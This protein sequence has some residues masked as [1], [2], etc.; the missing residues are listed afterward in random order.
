MKSTKHKAQNRR[1]I[2]QHITYHKSHRQA[3]ITQHTADN[4]SYL[5][6]HYSNSHP[7]PLTRFVS[8][9]C[10]LNNGK[11]MSAKL[12]PEKNMK[13]KV[14]PEPKMELESIKSEARIP[15]NLKTYAPQRSFLRVDFKH[16]LGG[17]KLKK[18][19]RDQL[20]EC[21]ESAG[22]VQWTN[23]TD[24]P[25]PAQRWLKS[26]QNKGTR[27]RWSSSPWARGPAN[28]SVHILC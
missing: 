7:H 5:R 25:L 20:R 17:Q 18:R 24:L 13:N 26:P 16:F 28:Y 19:S 1:R 21:R 10:L 27:F 6:L 2:T 11:Q 14:H 23:F 15:E 12:D 22:R 3:Q 9:S 8:P 4:M